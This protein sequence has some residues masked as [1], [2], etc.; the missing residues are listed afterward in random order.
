MNGFF[1]L[2]LDLTLIG[3][4]ATAIYYAVGLSRQLGELRASRAEM[5]KFILDFNITVQRAEAGI[6]GLKQAARSGGDDLEQL[7][8]KARSLRDELHFLVES[9]DQIASRLS[10]TAATATRRTQAD[11]TETRT[12]RPSAPATATV[13]PIKTELPASEKRLNLS[14]AASS[15]AERELLKVLEKLG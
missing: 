3:L 13:T 4:L 10:D 8:D 9:A 6:L 2:A 7:I 1:S 5:E 14:P 11:A 15:A 12:T